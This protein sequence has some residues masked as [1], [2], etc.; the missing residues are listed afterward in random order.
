MT[1]E[2]PN[3]YQPTLVTLRNG[4]SLLNAPSASRNVGVFLIVRAGSRD[5]TPETSGLA[6][7]LEHMF[8]KG[9]ER[10]PSTKIISREIDRLGASTNAYTDTE[11][12][13]Y[14]AEGPATA[15]TELADIITDMLSRP[16]FEAEEVE[17][18]RNVVLQELGMRLADPEGWIWDRIGS[19]AF[20]GGQPLSWSAAGFPAVIERAGRDQLVAY[21]KSF[22][23]PKSMCLVISGG[24]SLMAEDAERFLAGVP[25]ART[26]KRSAARWGLGDRYTASIRPAT[27]DEEP[28]T[29]MVFAVPGIPATDPDRTALSVMT[30]IL[31]GGMS[32]RLFQTVRERNGLCYSIYALHEGFDDCGL[33]A[34]STAT[35]PKDARRATQL[36]F[37]EFR[38]LIGKRV[39]AD[40][41]AAAKSAMIGRLL[42]STETAIAG[43]RFYGGRWRAGL[44]VETPDQRADAIAA[45]T[46]E[47]VQ[48]MAERIGAGLEQVRLAFVGPEDQGE[49]LLAATA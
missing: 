7:Y 11:E 24:S 22:Y 45:V 38:R 16:L 21:H 23:A 3:P 17:R 14:Y 13:A 6:H 1:A 10:R 49:E 8:F 48:A 34:I 37:K 27:R 41:L 32:S 26:R 33:F 29:R 20:G 47:Q 18:E 46:A 15:L 19:V 44:P 40:E 30:H 2:R 39:V 4:V 28:Q 35:R 31:G 43:A 5:E 42:R 36:S 25:N 12:V 9:T